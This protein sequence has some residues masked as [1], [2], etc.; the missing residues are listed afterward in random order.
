M[1]WPWKRGDRDLEKRVADLERM[2]PRLLTLMEMQGAATEKRTE[3]LALETELQGLKG[4]L[5]VDRGDLPDYI[6]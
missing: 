4:S 2:V 5:P 6:W 1:K 3:L